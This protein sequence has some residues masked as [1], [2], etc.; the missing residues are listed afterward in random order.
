MLNKK[1]T[2]FI[3]GKLKKKI[4]NAETSKKLNIAKLS[5][6]LLN[7]FLKKTP[8]INFMKNI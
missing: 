2:D 7:S 1:R 8:D 5:K 6:A 3:K 4:K